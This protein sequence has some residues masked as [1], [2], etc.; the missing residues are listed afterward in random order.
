[1]AQTFGQPVGIRAFPQGPNPIRQL[2]QAHSCASAHRVRT[3]LGDQPAFTP[4]LGLL[5]FTLTDQ[6]RFGWEKDEATTYE[7][8]LECA[9]RAL[10][11]D[12]TAIEANVT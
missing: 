6:A 9:A 1:M 5:G 2:C 11:V 7:A 4:A 8:A 3:G 12:P 10:A